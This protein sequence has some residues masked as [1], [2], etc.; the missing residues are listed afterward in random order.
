MLASTGSHL[1]ILECDF[2]DSSFVAK[3]IAIFRNGNAQLI[4]GSKRHSESS[5]RRPFKRRMLTLLYN[6]VLLQWFIG[7]PGTDTHGLKSI[8]SGCARK[9]CREA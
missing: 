2:L 3:S 4:V 1:S 5:D 9:L 7:Y 6:L 8:E